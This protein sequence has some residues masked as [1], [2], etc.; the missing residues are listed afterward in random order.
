MFKPYLIIYNFMYIFQCSYLYFLVVVVLYWLFTFCP[1]RFAF[2]DFD[3][4]FCNLHFG[5]GFGFGFSD[6]LGIVYDEFER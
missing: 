4:A 5:I 1:L 6:I 3:F 2:C